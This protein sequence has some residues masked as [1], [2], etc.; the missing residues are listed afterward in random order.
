MS[1]N[2]FQVSVRIPAPPEQVYAVFQ[3]PEKSKKWYSLDGM[4]A[5]SIELDMRKGGRY[6]V[7]LEILN[8]S[9]TVV[10]EY[11]EVIPNEK[12]VF[13]HQWED[14]LMHETLATV[15]FRPRGLETEVLVTQEEFVSA[16]AADVQR[17]A[18]IGALEILAARFAEGE[19]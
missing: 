8:E 7:C 14:K 15:L 11:R 13:T 3:D 12:L 1:D 2:Q 18:W 10:G 17:T 6:R 5:K 19:F 4:V 9:V 16:E